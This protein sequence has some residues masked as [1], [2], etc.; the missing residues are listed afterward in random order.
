ME[1]EKS[2][3]GVY[4]KIQSIYKRDMEHPQKPFKFGEFTCPEFEYLQNNIWEFTEKVD[5]MNIRALWTGKD[6]K[7]GGRTDNAQLPM[8]LIEALQ[9]M[10]DKKVFEAKFGEEA[11]MFYGEGYGGKIQQGLKYF[12]TQT[13]VVF[14]IRIGHWWMTRESVDGISK[15][16]GLKSVPLIGTGSLKGGIDMVTSGITSSWGDF[17]AEGIVGVPQIELRGRSGSRIITKIKC[18]DFRAII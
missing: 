11:V 14:D 10:F 7:F 8:P 1:K 12:P 16:V 5:G 2:L 15:E 3:F 18:C 6:F 17:E 13:F 9:E 4:H